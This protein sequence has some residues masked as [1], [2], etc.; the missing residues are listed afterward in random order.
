MPNAR[1]FHLAYLAMAGLLAATGC[2]SKGAA[3]EAQTAAINGTSSDSPGTGGT[4]RAA[5]TPKPPVNPVVV[6]Q[7]TLGDIVVEL[8]AQAAPTTT[9]EF[10][11]YVRQKHYD[12]TIFHQVIK[13]QV[14]AIVGG[15]YLADLTS[16]PPKTPM[17]NEADKAAKSGLHNDRGTIAMMRDPTVIDSAT[18][19]FFINVNQNRGLDHKGSKAEEF[20]YCPFGTVIGGLEVVDAIAKVRVQDTVKGGRPFEQMPVEAVVIKQ[21]IIR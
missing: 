2:G 20:G 3:P 8:N 7:T 13:E 21:V 14:A 12:G 18:C 9:G 15:Q 19:Q 16:R 6:I 1:K 10:L 5:K 4:S 11:D 17:R